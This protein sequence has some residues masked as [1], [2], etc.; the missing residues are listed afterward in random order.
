MNGEAVVV[1]D[2]L[3]KRYGDLAAV[4]GISFQVGRGEIFGMVGPNGAGKTTTVECV[5]GLRRPDA[6]R[7]TVLGLD[8]WRDAQALRERMGVQLQT[9]SLP[10][11]IKVGEAVGLFAS[12]YR[13]AADGNAL[14]A[15]LGLG[16]T[17]KAYV[18]QLS[19]GQRQRLFVALALINRP[20]VV[21]LDELTTGLDPQGRRATWDLVREIRAEGATVVLTTHFMDEAERLCD[22]VAIVDHGRIIA[23]DAP[24]TLVRRL[25]AE[26]RVVF[27]LDGDLNAATLG[28]LDGVRRVERE[29]E[30]VVVCGGSLAAVVNTL[31][32]DGVRFRN[33]RTEQPNLEDVFLALTGHRDARESGNPL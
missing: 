1:A 28:V 17:R 7:V 16:N 18:S 19:G 10:Q 31:E 27:D 6:G 30:R 3:A 5:E 29:G 4:D 24:A 12:F 21:F 20:E 33:L 15:R 23:L 8:P 25:G 11:R 2:G 22:R 13:Q 32:A 14:L 26:A 9:A